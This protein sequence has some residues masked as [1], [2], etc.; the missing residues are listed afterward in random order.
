[1]EINSLWSL[2]EFTIS[3]GC[4]FTGPKRGA[5]SDGGREGKSSTLIVMQ[6]QYDVL[7]E[8]VKEFL[9]LYYGHSHI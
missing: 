2:A 6:E 8:G 5:D 7:V 3:F 1:M 9:N 4:T